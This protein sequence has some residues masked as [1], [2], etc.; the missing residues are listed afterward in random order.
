[1]SR[2]EVSSDWWFVGRYTLAGLAERL[3]KSKDIVANWSRPHLHKTAPSGLLKFGVTDQSMRCGHARY[4][5]RDLVLLMIAEHLVH[6][7]GL[8]H[9]IAARVAGRAIVA[10]D[11]IWASSQDSLPSR[12]PFM[13]V[14]D[15]GSSGDV[16]I[17]GVEEVAS[18]ARGAGLPPA[19][20]MVDLWRLGLM[21]VS[22]ARMGLGAIS[23]IP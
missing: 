8:S 13:L 3:G 9:S 5:N 10:A 16:V 12:R 2:S 20:V 6:T 17:T 4:S 18:L 7:V 14:G 21:G 22:A 23:E 19:T 11:E 15:T 1:M